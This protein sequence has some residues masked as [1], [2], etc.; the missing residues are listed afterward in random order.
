MPVFRAIGTKPEA[1]DERGHQHRPQGA[2]SAARLDRLPQ[3]GMP[4]VQSWRIVDTMTM[5]PSTETPGQRDE[6]H[7]AETENGIPRS[8][9]AATPPTAANGTPVNTRAASSTRP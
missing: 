2:R 1:G 9:S 4:R 5:S 3:L 8:H 7:A 6:A